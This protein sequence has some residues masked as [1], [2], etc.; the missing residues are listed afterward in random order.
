MQPTMVPLL[1]TGAS[2]AGPTTVFY[3]V[4]AA[5]EKGTEIK[6][7]INYAESVSENSFI[8]FKPKEKI[9]Y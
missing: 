9:Q 5:S 2:I 6:I 7:P 4:A 3:K 8:H 1:L